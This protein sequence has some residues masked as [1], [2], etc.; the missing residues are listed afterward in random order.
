[1]T[2]D[3]FDGSRAAD[4]LPGED[5]TAIGFI[6]QQYF[7]GPRPWRASAIRKEKRAFRQRIPEDASGSALTPLLRNLIIYS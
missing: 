4:A 7:A 2:R 3:D 6:I 5:F 1:L